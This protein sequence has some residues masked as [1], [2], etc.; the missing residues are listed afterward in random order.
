VP[1]S[2][3]IEGLAL[4]FQLG[5]GTLIPFFVI[6]FSNLWIII[7]VSKLGTAFQRSKWT[8]LNVDK[9]AAIGG[10]MVRMAF[11]R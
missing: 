5:F 1:D 7:T 10:H 6:V 2:P 9:A 11:R 3:L 8:P 4:G